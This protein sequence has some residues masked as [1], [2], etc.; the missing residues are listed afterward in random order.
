[1]RIA[2]LENNAQ[3]ASSLETWLENVQ[4][5]VRSFD[6]SPEFTR[7]LDR[8]EFD[9]AIVGCAELGVSGTELV[10]HLR[11]RTAV[12][13][14]IMRIIPKAGETDIVNALNAGA[15]DC[16]SQP[17][18]RREF[19]ARVEA[20]ARRARR[21]S[22][23]Q[24]VMVEIGELKVDRKNRLIY[25]NGLNVPMTPKAYNLAVLMLLNTGK[26]F[27][28]E[29]LIDRLW[30]GARMESTRTLDTHMSRLRLTLGLTPANGWLLQ[31]V[32]QHGYRLERL[33]A[34]GEGEAIP[35]V[36]G[37]TSVAH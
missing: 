32:Y 11:R 17:L 19:I 35:R 15:D 29:Q 37:R 16:V 9:V 4:H 13:M 6:S 31:S 2:L 12:M 24:P 3:A 27:T 5:N 26:L 10:T 34:A 8:D 22:D 18:R 20:L 14:P 36:D 28:R 30:G 25:R 1:M 23:T 33:A 7:E 21:A